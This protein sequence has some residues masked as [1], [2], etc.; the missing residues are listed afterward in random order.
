MTTP[1]ATTT[2]EFDMNL[3]ARVSSLTMSDFDPTDSTTYHYTESIT[4]YDSLGIP[5]Q[6]DSYFVKT[7]TNEWTIFVTADGLNTVNPATTT[8]PYY[9]N[10]T[11]TYPA[12]GTGMNPT[13]TPI[14]IPVIFEPL[15]SSGYPTGATNPISITLDLNETTQFG[16]DFSSSV[17]QNG[18][19]FAD[20]TLISTSG[21]DDLQGSVGNDTA[22]FNYST[23]DII[24]ITNDYLNSGTIIISGPEG[25]DTL[26]SIE[27]VQFTDYTISSHLFLIDVTASEQTL[28]DTSGY[29]SLIIPG[30]N[31]TTILAGDGGDYI[32]GV[33]IGETIDG[34]NGV[35]TV[36]FAFTSSLVTSIYQKLDGSIAI[37]TQQGTTHLSNVENVVFKNEASVNLEGF[38]NVRNAVP[39]V[40]TIADS[41]GISVEST[42]EQ[43]SG[44]VD[45]LQYQWFGNTMN[46]VMTGSDYND[47]ISLQAGDDAANG[48]GGQ[49][50]LDGGAD[51][52]FL[53]GGT[54]AD[55]F[56]LDGRAGTVT[57]STITDFEGDSVNIWGWQEGS[58]QLILTVENAGA[59][60]YKGVTFHYDLNN[61]GL[62]ET[63]ITF[64]GLT[65]NQVPGS[66]AQEIEG[67]EY[68][69]FA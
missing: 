10:G 23:E 27:K 12:S 57:W 51:S 2:V 65:A 36:Q 55:T 18:G 38:L 40:F 61:D 16:S 11:I 67:N 44:P 46:N 54:G 58:S 60:G 21:N 22:V 6:L 4:V 32:V 8:P 1:S 64:S 43:Y 34:G 7:S 41:N 30:A 42:P 53:S 25:I 31:T 69:L 62:I 50:V 9:P 59:E 48:G 17:E 13:T 24:A 37:T 56:F 39:A 52:N 35:D 49:D 63:S 15:D 28:V 26:T 29:S 68:L 47:F 66:S 33:S 3:D 5:H 14:D 19:L 20:L 45:F